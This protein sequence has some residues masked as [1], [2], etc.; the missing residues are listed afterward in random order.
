MSDEG[1]P[2]W[3]RLHPLS[4]VMRTLQT[5]PRA[6]VGL[7]GIAVAARGWAFAIA[8]VV[9]VL[10]LVG[11]FV[12]WRRFRFAIDGDALR[13]ESGLVSLSRRVIPL[14][15]VQDVDIERGPLHRLFGLARVRV[16]TGGSDKDEGAL[17]GIAIARAEAL[18][19]ELRGRAATGDAASTDGAGAAPA[20]T[21]VYRLTWSRL[22]LAGVFNF[23]LV[24]IALLA[25]VGETFGRAVGLSIWDVANWAERAETR[26]RLRD[27]T[28]EADAGTVLVVLA[29]VGAVALLGVATGLVRTALAEWRFMLDR[30]GR[31]LVVRRGLVTVREVAVAV[32]RIQAARLSAGPL[33]R[34]L[35][36]ARVEVQTLG[37]AGGAGGDGQSRGAARQVLAPLADAGEIGA[38]L[39]H[40]L[41]VDLPPADVY[42]GGVARAWVADA[43]TLLLVIGAVAAGLAGASRWIDEVARWLPLLVPLAVLAVLATA[44]RWRAHRWHVGASAGAGRAYLFVRRGWWRRR[45]DVLPLRRAQA[46]IVRQGPIE[47]RLGLASVHVDS[48]G[49]RAA[50]PLPRLDTARANT[51]ALDL[52]ALAR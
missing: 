31:S 28:S 41:P 3:E 11:G 30:R 20:V 47:R 27:L 22:L 5:L 46:V 25:S 34:R 33:A 4:V 14:A 36:L 1:G 48:A 43:A 7:A 44:V 49:A 8:G 42:R 39:T 10:V 29:G 52:A 24:W 37:G 9:A 35:G 19:E 45:T 2:H 21:P 17:D 26:G 38:I 23:S 15:R 32:R 51:L 16:E 6:A 13:I 40:A 18:R 12:S 50:L